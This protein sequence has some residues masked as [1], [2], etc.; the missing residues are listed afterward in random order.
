M[1]ASE[2]ETTH[3]IRKHSHKPRAKSTYGVNHR[4][5]VEVSTGG[6]QLVSRK[7]SEIRIPVPVEQLPTLFRQ[8]NDASLNPPDSD[9]NTPNLN[10]KAVTLYGGAF[11][12]KL[13]FAS[14]RPLVGLPLALIARLWLWLNCVRCPLSRPWCRFL[15]AGSNPKSNLDVCVKRERLTTAC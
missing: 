14:L 7:P 10:T 8:L 12:Q 1:Q 11:C 13:P 4:N 9:S 2:R 3:Q 6:V 5:T 15:W